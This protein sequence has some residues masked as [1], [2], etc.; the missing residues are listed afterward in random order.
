M[1]GYRLSFEIIDYSQ[2]RFLPGQVIVIVSNPPGEIS[3]QVSVTAARFR[4]TG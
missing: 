3:S 1:S 2:G 4:G